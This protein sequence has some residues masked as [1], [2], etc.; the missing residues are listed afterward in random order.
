[1]LW[2]MLE[3]KII[4]RIVISRWGFWLIAL[5]HITNSSDLENALTSGNTEVDH[6]LE[7]F[8]KWHC[9]LEVMLI[10]QLL[11]AWELLQFRTQNQYTKIWYRNLP[12]PKVRCCVGLLLAAE[13]G[14]S[15]GDSMVTYFESISICSWC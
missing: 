4:V 14:K 13:N 3:G 6:M 2:I 15:I 9:L 12:L 5:S 10:L 8:C 7:R 11:K 1:M